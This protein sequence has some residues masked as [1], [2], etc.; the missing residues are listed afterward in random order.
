MKWEHRHHQPGEAPIWQM[1][2][3]SGQGIT[4][5]ILLFYT[6]YYYCDLDAETQYLTNNVKEQK[7]CGSN[8]GNSVVDWL[9]PW[10]EYHGAR[11]G[12]G[13]LLTSWESGNCEMGGAGDKTISFQA[14]HLMTHFQPGPTSQQH[15]QSWTHQ[16]VNPLIIIVA[17]WSNLLEAWPL[18]TWVY[19]WTFYI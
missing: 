8:L 18:N 2:V 3:L 1:R 5:N 17:S 19:W 6:H 15:I 12:R 14:G 16:W 4:V 13:M 7:W 9:I 10:H 11:H